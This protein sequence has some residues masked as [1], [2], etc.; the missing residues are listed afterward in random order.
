M[1]FTSASS[2]IVTTQMP[3]AAR[4]AL[5]S[6]VMAWARD[7]ATGELRYIMHLGPE[8]N[9]AKS[10][11]ECISCKRPLEAIN[12]GKALEA[13]KQRPHFRHADGAHRDTCETLT[14]RAIIMETFRTTG[15]LT[16]PGLQRSASFTGHSGKTYQASASTDPEPTHIKQFDFT[17][18][19]RALLTLDDGRVLEVMLVGQASNIDPQT[20]QDFAQPT[21]L[22][23]I[24]NPTELIGLDPATLNARLQ[25]IVESAHWCHHWQDGQLDAQAR[26]GAEQMAIDRHDVLPPE[27]ESQGLLFVTELPPKKAPLTAAPPAELLHGD[28]MPWDDPPSPDT[29]TSPWDSH[30]DHGETLL[31]LKA[32]EILAREGRML[33]PALVA[34]AQYVDALGQTH[35][36]EEEVLPQRMISFDRVILEKPIGRTRPDVFVIP[37]LF[38]DFGSHQALIEVTCTNAITT[39]RAGRIR[40]TGYPAI[41]VDLSQLA[42]R[43]SEADFTSLLVHSVKAKRW[44]WHPKQLPTQGRLERQL[45]YQASRTPEQVASDYLSALTQFR[46]TEGEEQGRLVRK[47]IAQYAEEFARLRVIRQKDVHNIQTW[48]WVSVV[49][50]LQSIRAD[51]GVGY[52][53]NTAWQ[54]INA[55]LSEAS[56]FFIWHP[57]YLMAIRTW[58]PALNEMQADTVGAWRERVV[59]SLNT[60]SFE[61]RRH[62]HMDRLLCLLFPELDEQ[63]RTELP[64]TLPRRRVFGRDPDENPESY[65]VSRTSTPFRSRDDWY[66]DLIVEA[67][68]ASRM[69]LAPAQFAE[70]YARRRPPPWATRNTSSAD[71]ALT[72]LCDFGYAKDERFWCDPW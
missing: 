48:D 67:A 37:Q 1:A 32:K 23:V 21:L 50:R 41:E 59:A 30:A 13:C 16:L 39:E 49:N 47:A 17:D 64:G 15:L 42:G 45:A 22:L 44:I 31:H 28:A 11:C 65:S 18:T 24:D 29:A 68:E 33:F 2:T 55:I 40:D 56:P 27:L 34:Q 54:V 60:N 58:Q 63:I 43:L 61:F 35:R 10:G 4:T 20:G 36:L 46:E 72:T 7:T 5:G 69:G 9:G 12:R 57:I 51:E 70:R 53:V 71:D 8:R 38:E 25:I 14:A 66:F 52:K 26:D 6:L 3:S 19:A 62:I